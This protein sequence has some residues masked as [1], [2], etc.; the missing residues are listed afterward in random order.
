LAR[1]QAWLKTVTSQQREEL[2]EIDAEERINRIRQIKT[3]QEIERL[4]ELLAAELNETEIREVKDKLRRWM[5][6]YLRSHEDEIARRLPEEARG[7]PH[8]R[9]HMAVMR[10]LMGP[11]RHSPPMPGLTDAERDELEGFLPPSLAE[12][13]RQAN[14]AE[15][16]WQLVREVWLAFAPRV[17]ED[18]LL[19]FLEQDLEPERR[20]EL[21]DFPADQ[22]WEALR[23][24][25]FRSRWRQFGG[26][27]RGER[28]ENGRGRSRGRR[29]RPTVGNDL[30]RPPFG[31]DGQFPPPADDEFGPPGPP[32]PRP[33]KEQLDARRPRLD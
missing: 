28:T 32:P 15:L 30:P 19:R 20:T 24:E 18:E 9:R 22:F 11:S 29:E 3:H 16:Q 5:A 4:G 13:L 14:S 17:S 10:Y 6:R 8:F 1:Y 21:K 25:Y 12:Q 23:T 2:K 26:R 33:S 7:F 31:R 27:R